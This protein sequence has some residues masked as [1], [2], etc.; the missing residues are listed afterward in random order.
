MSK[1]MTVFGGTVL[2]SYK[3]SKVLSVLW[4]DYLRFGTSDK[5]MIG[6]A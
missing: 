2:E 3:T 4:L 1:S 5:K 6:E